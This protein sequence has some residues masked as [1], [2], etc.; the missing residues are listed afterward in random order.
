MPQNPAHFRRQL[1]QATVHLRAS[2]GRLGEWIAVCGGCELQ[3]S[4]ER[5][6]Y[7]ALVRAIAHQQLHGRAAQTILEHLIAEFARPGQTFPTARQ[8]KLAPLER[9]RKCGFSLAKATAIQGIAAAAVS[10]E[11]P[12]RS[13]S[14]DLSNE[15]LIERLVGLRGVGRWTVEMFLI[16]T[17]GRL[18]VMPVDDFGIRAGV[19]HLHGLSIQPRPREVAALTDHM[20]PYRSVAAWYLWR[21]ADARKRT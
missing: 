3:V 15:E 10:G 12:E 17:L 19:Q 18:D 20:A 5:S 21:L 1:R 4:W 2:D 6:V 14:D 7:E 13:E 8:L 16:F 11:I 9:L